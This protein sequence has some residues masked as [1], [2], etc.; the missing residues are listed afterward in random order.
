MR[1][2]TRS[3][4]HHDSVLWEFVPPALVTRLPLRAT[5]GQQSA[6]SK[7]ACVRCVL[8]ESPEAGEGRRSLK[9]GADFR[10]SPEGGQP[11]AVWL[12]LWQGVAWM[13]CAS[14]VCEW[15]RECGRAWGVQGECVAPALLPPPTHWSYLI[16]LWPQPLRADPRW[17]A[18]LLRS[19]LLGAL[20]SEAPRVAAAPRPRSWSYGARRSEVMNWSDRRGRAC[21]GPL[22]I[23]AILIWARPRDAAA[24]GAWLKR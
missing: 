8:P 21:P 7:R 13:V 9:E 24:R 11:G 12:V 10:P 6:R 4:D 2:C 20:C 18:S 1:S 23:E 22:I 17:K 19:P 15:T 5:R 3:K 14:W 16:G